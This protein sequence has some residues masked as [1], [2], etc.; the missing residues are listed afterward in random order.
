MTHSEGWMN[1]KGY[2]CVWGCWGPVDSS[3]VD[4]RCL[5]QAR[6]DR[7]LD[8]CRGR[9]LEGSTWTGGT[10]GGTWSRNLWNFRYNEGSGMNPKFQVW[11][12]G[13]W[14]YFGL[15]YGRKKETG[16][17]LED[18]DK[19][20]FSFERVRERDQRIWTRELDLWKRNSG[21]TQA[22]DWKAFS[23]YV[24]VFSPTILLPRSSV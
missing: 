23:R 1:E 16:N 8:F 5:L 18:E 24:T 19:F 12:P 17:C 2:V 15:K 6:R 11:T 14:L 3:K 22:G 13:P 7:A 20:S 4:I 10:S 21:G 9:E